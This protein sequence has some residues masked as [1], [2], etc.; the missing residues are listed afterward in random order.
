VDI[1]GFGHALCEKL[2]G[3]RL[4]ARFA[5]E[6][7]FESE[8]LVKAAWELSRVHP[9]IRVFTHPWRRT[10]KCQP[11]CEVA[12]QRFG[13]RVEGCPACWKRS[14]RR[15]VADV[16]GMRNNFDVAAIDRTGGSLVVEVKWL[17]FKGNRAPNSEFQRFVG[18]CVLA[19]AANDM[20][21]GV[22]GLWGRRARPLDHHE[23]AFQ[24]ALDKAGVRLIVLRGGV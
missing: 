17:R 23:M 19:A 2:G 22:C 6:K 7:T 3:I 18:Q 10:A 5:D 20:V 8:I 21:I 11:N 16:F 13:D 24:E 4:G 12:E 1:S 14:K 15:N 9:E